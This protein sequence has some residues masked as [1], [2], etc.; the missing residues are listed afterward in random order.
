MIRARGRAISGAL[1]VSAAAAIWI[2][3][4]AAP[5][6]AYVCDFGISRPTPGSRLDTAAVRISGPFST[7]HGSANRI[8]EVTFTAGPGAVS[9]KRTTVPAGDTY[10]VPVGPLALN[11]SYTARVTAR[12][13]GT[14]PT[15][16]CD[17]DE[18]GSDRDTERTAGVSF[19]VSVRAQPPANVR[20][21]FDAGARSAT[22]TWDKSS[23]PD[24]AGYRITRKVGAAAPTTLDVP[25]EPRRW[26]DT[27]LPAEA[28]T[29]TYSVEAARNGPR[30]GTTSERSAAV[31][32][33][34][35]AIPARPSPPTSTRGPA[36]PGGTTRGGGGA[37]ATQPFTLGRS[38]SDGEAP[39][40]T[41]LPLPELEQPGNPGGA[42]S[43]PLGAYTTIPEEGGSLVLN[44]EDDQAMG[45]GRRGQ[46]GGDGTRQLA[47]VAAG[48]L[49]T[50]VAAQA[51]WL[52][53][54]ALLP[55]PSS[56]PGSAA[57]RGGG[58]ATRPTVGG[59]RCPR[60]TG[61]PPRRHPAADHGGPRGLRAGSLGG[62]TGRVASW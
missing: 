15:L 25:P 16:N 22:I 12:H 19:E 37:A 40:A 58:G 53:R 33:A 62:A 3:A 55:E 52:R 31:A 45:A 11:G 14:S 39:P 9:P 26:T 44:D 54:Q 61:W 5:A 7:R 43:Q 32:A 1:A 13:D 28:V 34:P 57:G 42:A 50:V 38:V 49:M 46:G 24:I 60:S 27:R 21:T 48:L 30:P 41:A 6:G 47:Y 35:L 36:G 8:I 23:D 20:T 51:L 10:D 18:S 29:L 2:L 59:R 17:D 56:G 4:G